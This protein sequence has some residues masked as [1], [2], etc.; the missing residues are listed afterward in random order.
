MTPALPT[1][2]MQTL[3]R[4]LQLHETELEISNEE[5]RAAE[6]ELAASRDRYAELYDFAPAGYLTLDGH[7]RIVGANLPAGRMLGVSRDHLVKSHKFTDFVV[8]EDRETW[9]GF[10]Q[11]VAERGGDERC[12][13]T[14][15]RG[16]AARWVARVEVS[17]LARK[18]PM[19][20]H[21]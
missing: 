16:D 2:D 11:A 18:P 8:P 21:A 1:R 3:V 5:L 9:R 4:E 12:D 7:D 15:K 14:L 13:I 20:K 10:R 19:G 6:K 17:L